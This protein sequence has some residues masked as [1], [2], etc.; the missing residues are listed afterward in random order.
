[1]TDNQTTGVVS[2][3][4]S[5]PITGWGG[6][7]SLVT[8]STGLSWFGPAGIPGCSEV[9]ILPPGAFDVCG[10]PTSDSYGP[11]P[12]NAFFNSISIVIS[13]GINGSCAA[14]TFSLDKTISMRFS[15]LEK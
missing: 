9:V 10:Y 11:K 15:D 3:S 6:Q 13:Y 4:G 1:M 12:S 2:Q 8:G 7:L 5:E 14:A